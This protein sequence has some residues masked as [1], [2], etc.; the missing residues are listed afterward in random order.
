MRRLSFNPI[1]ADGLCGAASAEMTGDGGTKK[2]GAVPGLAQW[3]LYRGS[4]VDCVADQFV[5]MRWRRIGALDGEINAG[6]K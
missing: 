1:S 2:R 6:A 3:S 5:D 4:R